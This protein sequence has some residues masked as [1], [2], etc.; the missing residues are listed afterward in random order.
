MSTETETSSTLPVPVQVIGRALRD[1]WDDWVN[2]AVLNLLLALAWLTIILGPPATFALYYVTNHLAHGQSLGPNGLIEGGRRYFM[3]SWRWMLLN[4]A[5][6]VVLG[7]SYI[8]YSS[9]SAVWADLLQA[10]LILVAVA[11]L[12]VQFY[13]LPYLMEQKEQRIGL[14]LRNGLFT[15]LAAPGYTFVVAGAAAL[16]AVLSI[17]TVAP[18]FLGGPALLASLGNRA[19]VERLE[20]YQ[21][22]E[23][24]ATRNQE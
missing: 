11:W 22:R 24:E 14:A 23:Q 21:V 13:A 8:F 7:V 4:L 10:A 20:T 17:G 19:V 18:L 6:V 15:A 16:V 5:V 3:T 1:W 9:L 2:M 12:V